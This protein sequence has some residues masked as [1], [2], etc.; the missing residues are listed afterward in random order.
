ME[1]VKSIIDR[2]R[3][4]QNQ[5]VQYFFLDS[6]TN[7][8]LPFNTATVKVIAYTDKQK[9]RKLENITFKWFRMIEGRNYELDVDGDTYNF[10]INDVGRTI[11]ATVTNLDRQSEVECITFGP[12]YLQ[13]QVKLEVEGMVMN[14]AGTF[15]VRYP[16]KEIAK[17]LLEEKVIRSAKDIIIEEMNLTP[18]SLYFFTRNEEHAIPINSIFP[19][20]TQSNPLVMRIRF[21]ELHGFMDR[22]AYDTDEEGTYSIYIKFFNRI[23][24]ENFLTL[25]KLFTTVKILS[26]RRELDRLELEEDKELF[27]NN[28]KHSMGDMMTLYGNLKDTLKRSIEYTKS[29]VE[30]KHA[31]LQYSE[32]LEEELRLT[33]RDLKET[34]SN[35][36]LA[37]NFNLSKIDKVEKSIMKAEQ[38]LNEFSIR[39]EKSEKA[40]NEIKYQKVKNELEQM[41]KLNEILAKEL[42][43]TKRHGKERMQNIYQSLNNIKEISTLSNKIQMKTQ[44]NPSFVSNRNSQMDQSYNQNN[45]VQ[46]NDTLKAEIMNLKVQLI[47]EKEGKNSNANHGD[48]LLFYKECFNELRDKI[49]LLAKGKYENS[50]LSGTFLNQSVLDSVYKA[51]V[52]NKVELLNIENATLQRRVKYLSKELF[53]ARNQDHSEFEG[54]RVSRVSDENYKNLYN[55]IEELKA[56]NENLIIKINNGETLPKD[57]DSIYKKQ[58]QVLKAEVEKLVE[59]LNKIETKNN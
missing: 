13:P 3:P 19:E 43:R 37:N 51:G 57:S 45:L 59:K 28:L 26:F 5:E 39:E 22:F 7:G 18:E 11:V 25:Y 31:V 30:E 46:E 55:Q 17:Q 48:D 29:V 10:S 6:E 15:E 34:F 52:T 32:L 42:K 1:I 41:K 8:Q 33:L 24:R 14:E 50:N 12:I 35:S 23:Y 53:K 36:K 21:R 27:N 4:E 20:P 49:G 47:S 54:E 2:I 9:L 16:Y 44:M 58:N 38:A 40:V 56:Q